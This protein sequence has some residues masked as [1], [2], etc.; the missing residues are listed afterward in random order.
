[1]ARAHY[2]V[3]KSGKGWKIRYNDK[4]FDYSTQAAAMKAVVEAA[5]KAGRLGHDSQAL[6]QG[7]DCKWQTG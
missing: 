5:H 2:Y 3:L 6:I 1:M 4:D 7:R